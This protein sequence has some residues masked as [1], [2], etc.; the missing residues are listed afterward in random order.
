MDRCTDWISVA[1]LVWDLVQKKDPAVHEIVDAVLA[2]YEVSRSR[3]DNDILR[4]LETLELEG[5][6]ETVP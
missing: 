4:L 5:L 3:C 1:A 6:I 2:E